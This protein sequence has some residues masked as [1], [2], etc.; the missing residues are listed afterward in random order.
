M[1]I[2]ERAPRPSSTEP[3]QEHEITLYAGDDHHPVSM[4][5]YDKE[6]F[7]IGGLQVQLETN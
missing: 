2:N 6:R 3:Q 7:Y 1:A 5:C 4:A